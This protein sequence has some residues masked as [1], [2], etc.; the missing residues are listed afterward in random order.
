MPNKSISGVEITDIISHEDHRGFF[1][2]AFRINPGM[3][4]GQGVQISHS[5]V[6][7]GVVKGW[8]GHKRQVQ[9]NYV[10]SGKLHVALIDVREHSPTFQESMTFYASSERPIG[11]CFP[12]GVLHG[13]RC[14]E[15]TQII[16]VTSGFYDLDDE[17]RVPLIE[18]PDVQS[19][20]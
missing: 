16:Y 18:F 17:V 2:E 8:H 10:V 11:Y 20:L 12:P 4:A 7:A 9:W 5:M 1:R 19:F 6:N 3:V 15:H 13:Y 14:Y